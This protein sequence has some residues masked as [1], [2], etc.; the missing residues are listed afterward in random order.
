LSASARIAAAV[1]ALPL[2]PGMRVLEVGCGPGVALRLV[3][4]RIGGGLV[5]G[6]DRSA[7]AIGQ[8][9]RGCAAEIAAGRVRLRQTA[10][11]DFVL[12]P[13]EAPYDLAFGF[14]VGAL[15]GR[16]PA[17][18]EAALARLAVALCPGGRLFADGGNP[19]REVM[20]PRL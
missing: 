4:A 16:H 20:L 11:E 10:V 12:E 1:A 15:D 8:A 18:G 19:L 17:A 2:R 6:I 13:G 14:R 7:T 3:A 9:E 5:L